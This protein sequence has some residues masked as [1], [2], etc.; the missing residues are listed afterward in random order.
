MRRFNLDWIYF[1]QIE[2]KQNQAD[3]QILKHQQQ[4]QTDNNTLAKVINPDASSGSSIIDLDKNE[5]QHENQDQAEQS[6]SIEFLTNN[7][8]TSI[9][10]QQITTQAH[11]VKTQ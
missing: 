8:N 9:I 2:Q 5:Q 10:N 6:E 1:L 7:I 4:Q 11:G 3:L